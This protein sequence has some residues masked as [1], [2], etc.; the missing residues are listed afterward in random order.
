MSSVQLLLHLIQNYFSY[1]FNPLA[2]LHMYNPL[3]EIFQSDKMLGKN[4]FEPETFFLFQC[5]L[6]S[7]TE[8]GWMSSR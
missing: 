8:F 6:N 4:I 3:R 2:F 1:T 5:H 7:F